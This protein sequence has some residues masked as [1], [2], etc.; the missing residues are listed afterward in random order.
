MNFIR[1]KPKNLP[2]AANST[3]RARGSLRT[4]KGRMQVFEAIGPAR[5]KFSNDISSAILNYLRDHTEHDPA[6][7]VFLSLFMMGKS[8]GRTRPVVMLQ[9][10]DKSARVEAF[11]LIN[12]SGIMNDFAGF[13]LGEMPLKNEFE[14]LRPLGSQPISPASAGP[15]DVSRHAPL[16]AAPETATQVSGTYLSPSNGDYEMLEVAITHESGVKSSLAA[17]GGTISYKGIHLALSVSHFLSPKPETRRGAAAAAPSV[18]EHSDIDC[19]ITGFSDS[20][21]GDDDMVEVT[22]RGSV[23]PRSPRAVDWESEPEYDSSFSSDSDEETDC[24]QLSQYSKDEVEQGGITGLEIVAPLG[25]V[26][27]QPRPFRNIRSTPSP[28]PILY[29]SEHLDSAFIRLEYPMP[30]GVNL[31]TYGDFVETARS[32]VTIEARTRRGIVH[33]T[34]SGT[35][36]L[37]RLPGTKDFQEVYTAKMQTPLLPGDCGC[38]VKSMRTEK[39]LGH[40]IAGST[41]S[42]LVLV[43]PAVRVFAQLLKDISSDDAINHL[44]P[45]TPETYVPAVPY[46]RPWSHEGDQMPED[47]FERWKSNFDC[48]ALRNRTRHMEISDPGDIGVH[49]SRNQSLPPPAPSPKIYPA[50]FHERHGYERHGEG[51]ARTDN[52]EL[53]AAAVGSSLLPSESPD[54]MGTTRKRRNVDEDPEHYVV[55]KK[56]RTAEAPPQ[57]HPETVD[58]MNGDSKQPNIPFAKRGSLLCNNENC[59]GQAFPDEASLKAHIKKEHCRPYACVFHFAGCDSFFANKNEWKRHVNTQHLRFDKRHQQEHCLETVYALPSP[60]PPSGQPQATESSVINPPERRKP[61]SGA[62][63][64]RKDLYEQHLRRI[65][66]VETPPVRNLPLL[67]SVEKTRE[68]HNHPPEL[69]RTSSQL[70]R[71]ATDAYAL[72]VLSQEVWNRRLPD[73]EDLRCPAA[74]CGE[75]FGGEGAFD[76]WLDHVALHMDPEGGRENENF[77][78]DEPPDLCD[79]TKRGVGS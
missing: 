24:D 10:D 7:Y 33:G 27:T 43:M 21:D 32:D 45:S 56:R 53:G 55:H 62:I 1:R 40:V 26:A 8:V 77:G 11:R 6:S 4:R 38:W 57:D 20:E 13:E 54:N 28:L 76:R 35:P 31:E 25:N 68:P 58:N 61:A 63:F 69:L 47:P 39:L 12:A 22:S 78:R 70:I 49:P 16:F 50:G 64:N 60:F 72:G 14:N 74:G 17:S 65:H 15:D 73:P 5:E 34:L 75:S 44:L 67:P 52:E 30:G 46:H 51:S 29:T 42:G 3:G 9:S 66:P 48:S 23:S 41:T 2:Y 37:V 18:S 36:L 19:E 71:E 79:N 59:S